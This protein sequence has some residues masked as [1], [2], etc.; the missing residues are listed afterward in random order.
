MKHTLFTA[1]VA[2][3]LLSGPALAKDDCTDPVADWQPREQLQ[4]QLAASGWQVD[5]VKVDDGCYEVR[6][7][8]RNGHRIEAKFSPASLQIVELEIEFDSSGDTSDYL[9]PGAPGARAGAE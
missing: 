3:S 1:I 9:L 2:G 7:L 6:G 5:R 4:A 8:D